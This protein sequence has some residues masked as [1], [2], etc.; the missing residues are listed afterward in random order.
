MAAHEPSKTPQ[1]SEAVGNLQSVVEEPPPPI[2]GASLEAKMDALVEGNEIPDTSKADP[3][4][5][6]KKT[7]SKP[8]ADP[9]ALKKSK[10]LQN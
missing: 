8:F 10:S 4:S 2:T 7:R 5:E 9:V 1:P 6:A 3:K